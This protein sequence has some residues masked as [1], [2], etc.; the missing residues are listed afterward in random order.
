MTVKQI[1]PNGM[2]YFFNEISDEYTAEENEL[3]RRLKLKVFKL[4]KIYQLSAGTG[5][6]YASLQQLTI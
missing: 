3:I 4:K 2:H 1:T 6:F 5:I